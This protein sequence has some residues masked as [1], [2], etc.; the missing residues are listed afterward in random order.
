MSILDTVLEV[1]YMNTISLGVLQGAVEAYQIG[2]AKTTARVFKER[3]LW[4][5]KHTPPGV[6]RPPCISGVP[7]VL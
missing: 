1:C 7:D 2:C 6:P 4:C 3:H 5:D